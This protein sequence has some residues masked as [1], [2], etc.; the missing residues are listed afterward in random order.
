VSTRPFVSPKRWHSKALTGSIV[1]EDAARAADAGAAD[2]AT[3][4]SSAET[5]TLY[6]Y[7]SQSGQKGIL[8]SQEI[9]P[10][11]R[12]S[13]PNDARHGDG[14]YFSD[15][16]PGTYSN[17]SLSKQFL[18]IPYQGARFSHYVKIDLTGINV[19]EGR[20]SVLVVP[21]QNALS[22]FGRVIGWGTNQ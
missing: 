14:Q 7:T 10:S 18:V 8:D 6:H 16:E 15:I 13:N 2:P 20:P 19:R 4:V 12:A 1:A 3:D 17:A 5:Q 22:I 21:N 11:L 9:R